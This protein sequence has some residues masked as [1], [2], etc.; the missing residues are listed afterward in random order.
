MS[1][2]WADSILGVAGGAGAGQPRRPRPHRTLPPDTAGEEGR[3]GH[4][5]SLIILHF[6]NSHTF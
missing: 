6:L 1:R 3:A 4:T 2:V 5:H